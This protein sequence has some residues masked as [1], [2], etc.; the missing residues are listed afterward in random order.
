MRNTEKYLWNVERK[1]K[2]INQNAHGCNGNP[3]ALSK[4]RVKM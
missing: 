2:G 4:K 1:I 3:W